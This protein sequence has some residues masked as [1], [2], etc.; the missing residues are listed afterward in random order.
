MNSILYDLFKDS[1]RIQ[2][3]YAMLDVH[4]PHPLNANIAQ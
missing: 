3:I 2:M 1:S 4:F